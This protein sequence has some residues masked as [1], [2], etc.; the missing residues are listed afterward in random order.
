MDAMSYTQARQKFAGIMDKVCN[1]HEPIIITRQKQRP[2][3]MISLDDYNALEETAYLLT[4]PKNAEKLRLAID[5]LEND[6]NFKKIS[7]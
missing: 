1:D 3:V 5:D 6:K 4:S 2:V 7:L